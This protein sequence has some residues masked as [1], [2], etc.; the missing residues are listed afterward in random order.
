[1]EA[2]SVVITDSVDRRKHETLLRKHETLLRKHET[3]LRI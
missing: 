1:V 3:L 2:V